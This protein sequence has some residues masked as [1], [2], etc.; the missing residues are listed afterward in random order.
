[1]IGLPLWTAPL[2]AIAGL[3]ALWVTFRPVNAD[4]PLPDPE[5]L[6]GLIWAIMLLATTADTILLA[7]RA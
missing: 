6:Y 1:M 3:L 4:H 7:V 2:T 5:R